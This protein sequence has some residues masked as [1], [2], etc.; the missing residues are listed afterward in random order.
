MK[1]KLKSFK[2]HICETII[3]TDKTTV[4]CENCGNE[5]V[6]EG[7]VYYRRNMWAKWSDQIRGKNET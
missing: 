2:C 6:L 7:G 5:Y 1:N 3:I 4:R